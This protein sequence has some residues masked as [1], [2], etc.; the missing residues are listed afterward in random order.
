MS[1]LDQ[2][3]EII[4]KEIKGKKDNVILSLEIGDD[5][6]CLEHYEQD[7]YAKY[8][9]TKKE[10][11]AWLNKNGWKINEISESWGGLNTNNLEVIEIDNF[12]KTFK[13]DCLNKKYNQL[14]LFLLKWFF[15]ILYHK[16]QWKFYLQIET[17]L[18]FH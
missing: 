11:V 14:N 6:Y 16:K 9:K 8:F 10:M 1:V 4:K 5:Y 17:Q 18:A 7:E 12:I 2:I 13:K 3:E 15:L